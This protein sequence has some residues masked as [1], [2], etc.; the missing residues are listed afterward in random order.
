MNFFMNKHIKHINFETIKQNLPKLQ[1]K[2]WA[3]V[4]AAMFSLA[5]PIGPTI[6]A[7]AAAVHTSA[8]FTMPAQGRVS[9][10]FGYR[11]HPITKVSK[12][13]AGLDLAG[14]GP[15]KAAQ[16]GTVTRARYHSGWG[17]YVKIDHGNGL[18]T[19]Y[20]HMK[21]GSLKVK[22]GQKVSRGQQI[23][24]MGTTGAS[25][26]VHLHFEVYKNGKQ[27]NPAPYLGL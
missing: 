27:V 2:K 17:W 11:V 9:S 22:E 25:T 14:G 16:G 10:Q 6:A 8:N 15:I 12:L 4:T 18:Q 3:V 20:A 24:T 1:F 23:G 26:G 13:H 7:E 5:A 21:S 19:L